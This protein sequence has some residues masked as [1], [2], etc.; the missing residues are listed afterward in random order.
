MRGKAGLAAAILAAHMVAG[1]QARASSGPQAPGRTYAS[2]FKDLVLATCIATAYRREG[3]AGADA[4]SSVAALRD[5]TYYDLE[6]GGDAI[7]KLV[8]IY[9]ERDYRHPVAD[10]E[11]A[12]AIRFDLL[13]CLDLYHSKALAE[14]ARR[15]VDRP[16]RSYRQD[17]PVR[18]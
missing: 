5:F 2:N 18:D 8:D 13:K 11:S 10:V 16:Q 3:N 14:Q 17:Y 4:G 15:L 12:L 6:Q 9:L 7:R 1:A